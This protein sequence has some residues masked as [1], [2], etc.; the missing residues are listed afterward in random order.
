MQIHSRKSPLPLERWL[1]LTCLLWKVQSFPTIRFSRW[2][3]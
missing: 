1:D 2:E 3:R